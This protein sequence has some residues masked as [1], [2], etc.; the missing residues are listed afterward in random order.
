[1]VLHKYSGSGN[2]FLIFHS[3]V[4]KNRSA[5]AKKLCD[6]HNG[7]G[8]DGLVVLLPHN[9]YAY[10][11]EFYNCDGS[12]ANMCG[13]ASRCTAHYAYTQGLAD[14][15]HSFLT[16]AGE[17]R[18]EVFGENVRSDLGKY[19]LQD[20][21][22]L[23]LP[24]YSGLWY[25]IDTGVPHLVHFLKNADEILQ[26]KNPLL[27]E[28]RHKYNANVNLA[29]VHADNTISLSTYERGVED[30]T[31]ACG[32]GMAAVFAAALEFLEI[33][34][35]TLIPLSGERL[36]LTLEGKNIFYE[37]KIKPIGT[38]IVEENTMADG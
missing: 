13:N 35:A 4:R 16:G 6:R 36:R 9:K 12:Q 28:L 19:T 15:K 11:W 2:D 24:Q 17:I 3:F 34:N 7:I 38:C 14:A 1:M 10:E 37:G 21:F 22:E 26:K 29:Y 30:I 8:A 27:I 25:L 18:V 23:H 33:S 32:T 31:L 20:R 5:L